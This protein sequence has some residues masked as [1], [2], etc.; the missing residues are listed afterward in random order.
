M[1]MT[2]EEKQEIVKTYRRK[3]GDTGSS[4]VQVA[5]LTHR[6]AYLTEHMKVHRKDFHSRRGLT[7]LSNQRRKLLEYL[8]RTDLERY[9][10][11]VEQLALRY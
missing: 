4:E 8:K 7:A 11:L 9:K 2:V 3:E 10:K 1:V 6:I 5:L